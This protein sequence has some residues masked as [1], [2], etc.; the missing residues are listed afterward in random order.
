MLDERMFRIV[1]AF[2][3]S[4]L[5]VLIIT[6]LIK[7]L[8]IKVG[9]VDKPNHRKIH[10]KTMPRMGGLAIFIGV[11]VGVVCSGIYHE[12]KMT[13]IIVGAFVIIFLG[14]IDDRYQLSAKVKFIIQL[15][16]G[17]MIVSTG[18]KM[19]FFSVPFLS[20]RIELG[21][22][23]YPL[24]VLWIVG[25]TNAMNFIDGL[26]GLAAGLSVIGLSTIAF[27]AFT[28]GKVLILSLSLVVIGSTLGFLVYNFHPAKIFMGDTG[29]LFLGYVISILSLLG[30]Y[31]SV[32]LFS[33]VI[34]III[35]G[36]PIFD[37]TFAVIRRIINNQPFY[38]PDKSHIHHRLIAYGLSHRMS[39]VIIYLIGCI[40]SFSAILLKSATVW[41]SLF[42]IFILIL[43][44]QIIV[45]I[46]GL[47][48]EQFKPFIKFY[49][50]MIK[51]N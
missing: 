44:I 2:F 46:T 13:A 29:S 33:I 49:K 24:T 43:F 21:W 40:F 36:V 12:T 3:V 48:S 39:V 26:D 28:G 19:E 45:E 4:V 30:L 20:E 7:K 27:M 41:L 32:T 17:I 31:K 47:V 1:V 8:A 38:T 25:I 51:R 23:S 11:I 9:A 5:T 14:I 16:V 6:P 15:A 34:P 42:I 10:S 35:L 37:T 18:L 22:L 50:R